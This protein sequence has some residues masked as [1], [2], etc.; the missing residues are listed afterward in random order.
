M[1][2]Y[3]VLQL[4]L[5]ILAA[6]FGLFHISS[7][8]IAASVLKLLSSILMIPLTTVEHNRSPRPSVLLTSYLLLS[9]L[10]DVTQV[11]TLYLSSATSAELSYSNLFTAAVALKTAILV[12]ESRKK[13]K[14]MNWNE[15]EHSP[16]ETS[17][18]LSLV[19]FSG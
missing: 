12:L 16:E 19:S 8:F 5:L 11:R 18:I 7:I 6:A 2:S 1:T 15:K 4:A 17:G 3:T 14:W 10:F 9:L 13:S